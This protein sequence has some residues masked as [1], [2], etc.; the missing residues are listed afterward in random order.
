MPTRGCPDTPG[1]RVVGGRGEGDAV[2]DLPA[3]LWLASASGGRRTG[4]FYELES[5]GRVTRFAMREVANGTYLFAIP[6]PR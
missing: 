3:D 6:S 5:D 2:P 4:R 1:W